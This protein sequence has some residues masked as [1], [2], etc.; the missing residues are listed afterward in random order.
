M[1]D[2]LNN[3]GV[4]VPSEASEEHLKRKRVSRMFAYLRYTKD[5]RSPALVRFKLSDCLAHTKVEI[6]LSIHSYANRYISCQGP[7]I[8]RNHARRSQRSRCRCKSPHLYIEHW[9]AWA[10]SA[11]TKEVHSQTPTLREKAGCTRIL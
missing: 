1:E 2:L 10:W 8:G 9:V 11:W 5:D 6:A 7:S 3:C 4:A